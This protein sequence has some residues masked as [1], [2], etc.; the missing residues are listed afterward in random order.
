VTSVPPGFPRTDEDE[1]LLRWWQSQGERGCLVLEVK[2]GMW[3][4]GDWPSKRHHKRLDGLHVP[5]GPS[6][7]LRWED[8]DRDDFASWVAGEQVN[9]LESKASLNTDVIGQVVAGVDMFSR[10]YPS[11]GQIQPIVTVWAPADPA[12]TWVCHKRGIEVFSQTP[13]AAGA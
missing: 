9:L 6:A 3:G 10:S 12:L 1:L 13:S 4:P 7:I 2:L 8:T 11:A 5:S